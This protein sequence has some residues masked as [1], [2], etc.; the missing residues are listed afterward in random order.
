MTREAATVEGSMRALVVSLTSV[1]LAVIASPAHAQSG[2]PHLP[3]GYDAP[4]APVPAPSPYGAPT[5][6][7]PPDAAAPYGSRPYG[8]RPYG[9]APL[10]PP[11]RA[12]PI[13]P[14]TTQ[15]RLVPVEHSASIRGL[16]LPGLIVL[17]VAWVTTWTISSS[18]FEGDAATYA[19][20]PVIGP[21]LMLTQDLGGNDAGI[22]VSGVVQGLSA[23]ALVLGLSIK[24]T[25]TE[26]E[27]VIDPATGATA[28][29]TFDAISLPG[30]GLLGARVEL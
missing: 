10:A 24:R 3:P 28:R 20:I 19:W 14:P 26:Q 12:A 1:A 23:L 11:P 22:I 8:S 21:W 29:V 17:P 6:G 30:G 27:Y 25:W 15:A 9:Y 4:S 16:W 5:Y 13:A 18:A 7:V 2:D